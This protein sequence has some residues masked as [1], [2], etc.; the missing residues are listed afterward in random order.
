MIY[1]H[2]S[3]G[4]LEPQWLLIRWLI[5]IAFVAV[6]VFQIRKLEL[7]DPKN[8]YTMDRPKGMHQRTFQKMQQDVIDA[9]ERE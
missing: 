2:I 5:A 4:I 9:I 8:V 1:V 6:G 7:T 3:D